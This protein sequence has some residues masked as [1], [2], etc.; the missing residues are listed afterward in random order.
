MALGEQFEAILEAAQ[1]G[2]EEAL[3]AIYRDPDRGDHVP[4]PP[5]SAG[6]GGG[7]TP[8]AYAISRTP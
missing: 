4:D 5:P 3:A 6:G 1:S 8:D 7:V 2:A